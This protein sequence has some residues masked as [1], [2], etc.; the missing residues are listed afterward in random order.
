MKVYSLFVL[1]FIGAAIADICT[2]GDCIKTFDSVCSPRA[3]LIGFDIQVSLNENSFSDTPI[4]V[5]DIST[6]TVFKGRSPP[7]QSFS[8]AIDYSDGTPTVLLVGGRPIGVHNGVDCKQ[9]ESVSRIFIFNE[10]D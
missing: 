5:S 3:K 10:C 7:L 1:F 4:N 2:D 9:K 6:F 8:M